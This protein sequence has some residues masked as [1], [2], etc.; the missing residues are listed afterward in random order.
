MPRKIQYLTDQLRV[1]NGNVEQFRLDPN[2][3]ITQLGDY[4]Q[5]GD[6]TRTGSLTQTGNIFSSATVTG[7]SGLTATTGNIFASSGGLIVFNQAIDPDVSGSSPVTVTDTK[8]G[9]Y[10][11]ANTLGGSIT[12]NLPATGNSTGRK[13]IFI[14]GNAANNMIITASGAH[15][16]GAVRA[17][18]L[19]V[20]AAPSTTATFTGGAIGDYI[21][22]MGIHNTYLLARGQADGA[23]F[24][25][26]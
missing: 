16:R 18:D 7:G 11:L 8:S 15:I 14:K 2:G 22:I 26:S 5:T 24:A 12:Y 3:D 9:S 17:N 4:A 19:D 6:M 20:Q 1:I 10:Y 23:T 13:W 25:W 21:E